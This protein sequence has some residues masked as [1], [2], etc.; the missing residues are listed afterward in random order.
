[1]KRLPNDLRMKFNEDVGMVCYT[2][3]WLVDN[4]A[5]IR[6]LDKKKYERV[7]IANL[8]Q[9]YDNEREKRQREPAPE[10]GGGK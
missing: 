1:M 9:Y 6:S 3:D 8:R 4:G 10:V 7:I 2:L 5:L